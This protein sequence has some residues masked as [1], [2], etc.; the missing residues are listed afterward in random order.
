MHVF[1]CQKF[2]KI[3][4]ISK[5]PNNKV[6]YKH[7]NHPIKL[8]SLS[9]HLFS[10]RLWTGGVAWLRLCLHI[11]L[12]VLRLFFLRLCWLWNCLAHRLLYAIVHLL[13][14]VSQLLHWCHCLLPFVLCALL[15][16]HV[17]YPWSVS[18]DQV[19]RFLPLFG[20]NVSVLCFL[21]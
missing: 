14:L 8:I 20:S 10:L 9:L 2:I 11:H 18:L 13:C 4:T 21:K 3:L 5:K 7:V 15:L 1:I 17:D 19:Q 16:L 6:V 12:L